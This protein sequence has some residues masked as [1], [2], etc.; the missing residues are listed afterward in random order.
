MKTMSERFKIYQ[1]EGEVSG[2][3]KFVKCILLNEKFLKGFIAGRPI[4]RSDRCLS[5]IITSNSF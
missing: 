3:R 4:Q 5:S 2:L 1:K